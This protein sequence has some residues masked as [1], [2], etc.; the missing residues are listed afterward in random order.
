MN[1][2]TNITIKFYNKSTKNSNDSNKLWH[3]V[4]N[5][6]GTQR[7]HWGNMWK[8]G[9]F[10]VKVLFAAQISA[11][12]R[13]AKLKIKISKEISLEK[14]SEIFRFILFFFKFAWFI[15]L[16]NRENFGKLE[17]KAFGIF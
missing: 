2:W 15:F 12:N 5:K 14:K 8:C 3:F 4:K 6:I 9:I 16:E 1:N 13:V 10:T 17:K 7:F 11:T